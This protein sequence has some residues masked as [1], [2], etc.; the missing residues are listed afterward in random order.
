MEP[1]HIFTSKAEKYAR[2]RWHYSAQA[3]QTIFEVTQINRESRMADIGAGTGILTQHFIGKVKEVYA[4]EPNEAMRHLARGMLGAQPGCHFI[5]GRAEATTLPD[6]S[7]DLITVAEAFNWFDPQPTQAEFHRILKS[8]GW[9]AK[10]RNYGT[11]QELGEA[12]GKIYPQETDTQAFMPG[13]GTPFS[14][15]FG[16]DYLKQTFEFS[17][18]ETWIE[19]FGALSSASFAPDEDSPYYADFEGAARR[20]FDRYSQEGYLAVHGATEVCLGQIQVSQDS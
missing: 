18:K 16:G 4:V 6:H 17:V 3:I 2:Y 13:F 14:F 5:D 15:Y 8:G 9:L 11:D 7:V 10:I 1:I 19:F 12:F 20:V